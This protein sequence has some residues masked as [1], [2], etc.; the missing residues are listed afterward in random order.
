MGNSTSSE[1]SRKAPQKLSKPRPPGHVSATDFLSPSSLSASSGDR[2]CE[3][4]LAGS[5]VLSVEDFPSYTHDPIAARK[6]AFRTSSGHLSNSTPGLGAIDVGEST[7]VRDPQTQQRGRSSGVSRSD[8]TRQPDRPKS[9]VVDR[10]A[11]QPVARAASRRRHVRSSPDPLPAG[12]HYLDHLQLMVLHNVQSAVSVPT[13]ESIASQDPSCQSTRPEDHDSGEV[14]RHGHEALPSI[15]VRRRSLIQTPGLATRVARESPRVLTKTKIERRHTIIETE[16]LHVPTPRVDKYLSLTSHL[17]DGEPGE[18][19][20][21]PCEADYQQL[22]GMKFGT[23]RIM[24]GSPA[25]SPGSEPVENEET[26]E[27]YSEGSFGQAR[28]ST[29][30]PSWPLRAPTAPPVRQQRDDSAETLEV[31]ISQMLGCA[32]KTVTP[33][34]ALTSHPINVAHVS[35]SWQA[36]EQ[37]EREWHATPYF[38]SQDPDAFTPDGTDDLDY[39]S[40]EVFNVRLDPN[41]KSS[42]TSKL[43]IPSMDERR[44]VTRSDSGFVSASTSSSSSSRAAVSNADSGYSSSFS[45]RSLRSSTKSQDR[46]TAHAVSPGSPHK[47]GPMRSLTERS[48]RPNLK[49]SRG[50]SDLVV[51]RDKT[52]RLIKADKNGSLPKSPHAAHV[53]STSL[54]AATTSSDARHE[55]KQH[56]LRRFGQPRRQNVQTAYTSHDLYDSIPAVPSDIQ[57]SLHEHNGLFPT[58]SKRV[59][60][61]VESSQETL[62][63]IVSMDSLCVGEQTAAASKSTSKDLPATNT[64]NQQSISQVDLGPNRA[65]GQSIRRKPV[66]SGVQHHAASTTSG[67]TQ[68]R[69]GRDDPAHLLSS[70]ASA[71]DLPRTGA[72][73]LVTPRDRTQNDKKSPPISLRSGTFRPSLPPPSHNLGHPKSTPSLSQANSQDSLRRHRKDPSQSQPEGQSLAGSSHHQ[74]RHSYSGTRRPPPQV[75]RDSLLRHRS[76]SAPRYDDNGQQYRI[77]HSYNSPA[78]KNSPIWG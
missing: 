3:S 53:R 32:V 8:T 29:L 68:P 74:T 33:A 9:M 11:V 27:I 37:S 28:V 7:Q 18:R 16:A 36:A 42:S 45:L 57:E 4:Y 55:A 71:P 12:A 30:E 10:S 24:N 54:E 35:N 13:C 76:G 39:L 15:P 34:T 72:R 6:D 22:G 41:A 56:V 1:A 44:S 31:G 67:K 70:R 62:K 64:H 47:A 20:V 25:I 50:S 17:H 75:Y 63:T 58:A 40:P 52:R 14:P 46:E 26:C 23:L 65:A 43:P 77:L 38:A 21:T 61:R 19:A 59:A 60:L 2:Y 69:Y 5:R 51:A 49:S 78:Y 66:G 48:K 73:P